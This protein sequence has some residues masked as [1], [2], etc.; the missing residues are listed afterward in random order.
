MDGEVQ[1]VQVKEEKGEIEVVE[2]RENEEMRK[3]EVIDRR[4]HV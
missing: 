4:F 3:K 2:A 1:S